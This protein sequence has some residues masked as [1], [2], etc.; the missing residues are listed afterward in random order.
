MKF[1]EFVKVKTL[2]KKN[3]VEIG[4]VGIIIDALD[5]PTEGYIVEFCNDED[6]EPWATETYYPNEIELVK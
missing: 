4:E 5:K 6:Y 2:V 3:N 1:N